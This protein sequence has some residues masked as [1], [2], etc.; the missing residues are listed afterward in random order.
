MSFKIDPPFPDFLQN[1]LNENVVLTSKVEPPVEEEIKM[2]E[3]LTKSI[4][5]KK[6]GYNIQ[7]LFWLMHPNIEK[8]DEFNDKEAHFV[9]M[10]FNLDFGNMRIDLYKITKENA[11]K[12]NVVFLSEMDR[13]ANLTLY[14]SACFQIVN[15]DIIDL[16]PMEQLINYTG[17][18]WQLN[19]PVGYVSKTKEFIGLNIQM[20][21]KTSYYYKF[22]NS[23]KDIFNYA[24]RYVV[25]TGMQL[26]G[27][28][29]IRN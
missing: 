4:E 20:D 2:E 25:T 17:E 26:V 8:K 1:G 12:N 23:Q 14:P 22:I 5:T 28:N 24:C 27:M 15:N 16:H 3:V 11:I 19:R 7:P 9:T 21:N 18:D 10:S 13:L 29:K 6:E